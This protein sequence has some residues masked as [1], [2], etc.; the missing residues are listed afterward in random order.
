MKGQLG[1][2][3]WYLFVFSHDCGQPLP[4]ISLVKVFGCYYLG[5]GVVSGSIDYSF[6]LKAWLGSRPPER[7]ARFSMTRLYLRFRMAFAT[8]I[9]GGPFSR[10]SWMRA[11]KVP[12]GMTKGQW[13]INLPGI[14]P[15]GV[16]QLR[17]VLCRYPDRNDGAMFSHQF[18]R[19]ADEHR[20]LLYCIRYLGLGRMNVKGKLKTPD[21][22]VR[23]ISE[24]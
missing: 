4:G 9:K 23:T 20:T 18:V 2:C 11:H 15:L 16:L 19:F 5:S 6:L 1:M 10:G 22:H 24:P 3:Q 21:G 7:K 13:I 12:N 17:V 8:S 14:A